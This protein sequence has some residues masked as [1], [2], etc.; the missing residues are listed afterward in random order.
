MYIIKQLRRK[1]SISQS[2]LGKEIGVS[3]RTIQLYER[4]DANI[5]I[6]NL[7]KIAE[8]FGLTIAELYMHEVNDMGEAYTKR[9]PFIKHGS[10]FYPLEHGKY[11]VMAP[12]VL[13]EWHQKYIKD[14]QKDNLI[15]P[16]QGGF[17]IDFLT[18][19]PHRI[20]EVSGDSMDDKSAAAIPN[21]AYVLGLEIKK[22]SLTRNNETY[23]NRSYVL[24][25]TDRI[26][27]KRLTGYHKQHKSLMCHNLNTSPEFQDFELHLDDV[28]Q[29][30]KVVKKQF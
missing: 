26:I 15:N 10:V 30:F 17:I 20:F 8:Y 11:L 19:E 1:N 12:L 22:E 6:K 16:F 24:V 23:W 3:L 18:D 4:K 2:Q 5:P 25:C 14:V 29:V 13:V 9:Q 21:K 28:L 7:T 27:C